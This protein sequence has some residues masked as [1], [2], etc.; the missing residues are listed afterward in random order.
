MGNPT[1]RTGVV[2]QEFK[3]PSTKRKVFEDEEANNKPGVD[4]YS[5]EFQDIDAQHVRGK[6]LVALGIG[7]GNRP[8]LGGEI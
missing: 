7:L 4:K 3:N 6:R 1:Q 8:T 2:S 5:E